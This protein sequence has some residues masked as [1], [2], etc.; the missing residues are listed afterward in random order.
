MT[1]TASVV[2]FNNNPDSISELVK[3]LINQGIEY[4]YLIDNSRINSEVIYSKLINTEYCHC[5]NNPG[6]GAAHNLAITKSMKKNGKYH[7]VVNPDIQLTKNVISKMVE[8]MSQDL[9]IGMM[10]P[11]ILNTD[12][13]VQYLPK[14]LPSPLSL[15]NR[16]LSLPFGFSRQF[17]ENYELRFVSQDKIYNC[18][19]I[20]GC[21]TLLNLEVIRSEG[22]YDETF[23]L[24]FED[25]DL[26]RRISRNFKT[27]YFP[28]VHV[29]H[30]Y[31]SGAN[32]SIKLFFSF[33]FS[34][35]KY[36]NKWGWIFDKERDE[37]NKRTLI[38]LC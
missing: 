15:I 6:F 5:P 1:I 28:F 16:K 12:G 35:I 17:I 32:K 14:L 9:S 26:S 34:A 36:F 13:S 31:D 11:Q 3:S 33:V 8:F 22:G 23:F 25:F 20:S 7:F 24:Y 38:Q 2:L 29:T 19:I 37:I 18:P 21:F 30:G 27:L 4:I 10:M